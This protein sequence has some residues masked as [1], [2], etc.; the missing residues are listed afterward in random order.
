MMRRRSF[1]QFCGASLAFTMGTGLAAP[2]KKPNVVIIYG[3]DVGFG[4][5]GIYGSTL[6]PT[7]NIDRLAKEGLLFTDGHCS[8]ATCT[9]SRY[10]LLTGVHGFRDGVAI[11]PPNAPLTI[12]TK[13]LTLPKL[14]Q[15]AG[16]STG[17]VGKWHL[18]LGEKGTPVDW[19][20]DVKPGPLEIGFDHSFLLPSTNDRVPCVYLEG[21]RVR[22]L[23]PKDPLYVGTAHQPIY[24]S[25]A[26][27][28]LWQVGCFWRHTQAAGTLRV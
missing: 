16:Y 28:I 23:D 22:N 24:P 9:P 21:H 19:N 6:I 15:Q 27:D 25:D 18:G 1:V 3:D 2:K 10:S 20:G 4:D 14:F 12:S 11:L 17:V 8:A 7:P 26:E 5:V 13:A